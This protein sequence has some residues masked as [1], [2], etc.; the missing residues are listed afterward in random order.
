MKG[1]LFLGQRFAEQDE[2]LGKEL[3]EIGLFNEKKVATEMMLYGHG[4]TDSCC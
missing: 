3:W 1:P 4:F 2:F